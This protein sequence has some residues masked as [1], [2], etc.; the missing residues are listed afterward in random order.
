MMAGNDKS[1]AGDFGKIGTG[2]SPLPDSARAALEAQFGADLSNV[3]VMNNS[4]LP[5]AMGAKAYTTGT[6]IHF[7]SGAYQPDT[8][9]GR[10]V[11]AHE[12]AHVVQ[13]GK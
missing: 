1:P 13:Q 12:L 7:A 5:A 4:A 8:P 11:I 6:D 2:G 3:R 10:A 9:A